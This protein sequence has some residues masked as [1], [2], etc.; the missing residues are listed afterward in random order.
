[1][2]VSIDFYSI[3]ESITN[4]LIYEHNKS[5]SIFVNWID[6]PYKQ[7]IVFADYIPVNFIDS[8]LKI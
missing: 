6:I 2:E 8:I 7:T 4:E 5:K 3:D 1:M